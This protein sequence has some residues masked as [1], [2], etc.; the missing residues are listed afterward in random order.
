MS[1]SRYLRSLALLTVALL[2]P[3]SAAA[4]SGA[5]AGTVRD[6]TGSALPGVTV[7]VSSPA[8]IER[9]RVTVAGDEGQ[10]RIIDLRPGVYT[11]TFTLPGFNSLRRQ[12]I[13][14]SA[15]VTATV[16]GELRVG[17]LE[18]TITVTGAAPL[19]DVQ[20]VT[21][22]TVIPREIIEAIPTGKLWANLSSLIPGTTVR[23][24][25]VGSGGVQDVGGAAGNPILRVSIH[26]SGASDQQVG[27]DGYAVG[28]MAGQGDGVFQFFI[29]SLIQE[30]VFE[31]SAR[32]AD[33]GETGGIRTN[34][35]SR[36][37]GNT[38][39]GVFS[40]NFANEELQ[41]N[42]FSAD[43]EARGLTTPNKTKSVW[44]SS[45]GFG[46]PIVRDKLWF[47][48]GVQ[49]QV[50][51]SYI[52]GKFHNAN[53]E[54]WLF[55]PD[56]S[57]PMISE[58]NGW[59]SAT[60]LTWQLSSRNR[61]AAY[62]EYNHQCFCTFYSQAIPMPEAVWEGTFPTKSF[63]A[64]WTSTL[65]NRL[66]LQAGASLYHIDPYHLEAIGNGRSVVA[67]SGPYAGIRYGDAA[68]DM[69]INSKLVNVR[70]S[71]AY[72][73]G[74]HN[75]KFGMDM[76]M[77]FASPFI[78]ST[79]GN[80]L[81]TLVNDRPNTV[82]FSPGPRIQTDRVLPNL[83]IY[84]Q[85]QWTI[86]RLTLNGALRFDWFRTSYPDQVLPPAQYRPQELRVQGAEVFNWR[87]LNPRMGFAYDVFGNGRTA[88]KVGLSRYVT[89]E[90]VSDTQSVN[91]IG[92]VNATQTRTW[93][94]DGDFIIEGDPL[95][96]EINGELGRSNNQAFGQS[97]ITTRLDPRYQKG[98]GVRPF[99]WE[100]SVGLQ[101]ELRPG[102]STSVS[103]HRRWFGNFKLNDNL[104]VSP[105]DY[106]AFCITAPL[107]VRLPGGGGHR[108]CGLY[109]TTV[110]ARPLQDN[111]ITSSAF[112]DGD[113]RSHYD[114]VDLTMN[115]RLPRGTIIAGGVSFGKTMTDNCDLKF[116]SPS[117][118]LC[119]QE[120]PFQANVKLQGSYM[121]PWDVRVAATFQ[122]IPGPS[123]SATYTAS[124][125]QVTWENPALTRNLSA[126]AT[127]TVSVPLFSP[128]ELYGERMNQLDARFGKRFTFRRTR[129]EA[130][131]DVFNVLNG[132]AVL[133]HNNAY[134][135]TGTSW[136]VPFSILN[137][138]LLKFGM[139]VDF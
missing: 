126:G 66:L 27:L 75:L 83:G 21:Q 87:D 67:N 106:D 17:T 110:A 10:Y 47:F 131:F 58:Q 89:Q 18:E 125:A 49:K 74:S 108:I 4:Q 19:V 72:V 86:R 98:Y 128:T 37:G 111:V 139:Q 30:Y 44:L 77:G 91:P 59:G 36:E 28:S 6:N 64:T 118:Y 20:N 39:R 93:T 96:L 34:V 102:L 1:T 138:R 3:M 121:L 136:L 56:P 35:V 7:E 109:D 78:N 32:G 115:A 71:L 134:G 13:E 29:D 116:D 46:G 127:A 133:S 65:S 120:S 53:Q 69:L 9:V 60:R 57:R 54:G 41:F 104:K 88:V 79:P 45:G 48:A 15:G 117:T 130:Q 43:L 82:T 70:N 61:V 12:G 99:N 23:G 85:D 100:T 8:L 90:A 73:T 38:F 33:S 14:L 62:A 132:N 135:T 80:V 105:S 114:G 129:L 122:S 124:N 84:A 55:V 51:D 101:H 103:Y 31:T 137:G 25:G 16:N 94:D 11:V 63:N 92:A 26:G 97:V 107:D 22:Q 24:S 76:R 40:G 119:H 42:N 81:Y 95:N 52:A 2:I 123:I 5:I 113:Q 112:Y 68:S 50:A